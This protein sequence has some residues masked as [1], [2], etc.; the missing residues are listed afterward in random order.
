MR[1][2]A[3][4]S[5]CNVVGITINEY[6]VSQAKAY[7]QKAGMDKQ[8]QVVSGNFLEKPF[9]DESFDGTYSIEATCHAPILEDVYREIFRVLKPGSMY[10]SYEWVTRD[11]YHAQNPKHVDII[12]GI[13]RGNPLPG[14]RSYTDIAETAKYVGI[15]ARKAWNCG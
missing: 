11:L 6:Q 4:H 15:G 9:E 8:C 7:N 14:L 1:A 12:Q 2:I 3:A 5:G 13:E 10:V